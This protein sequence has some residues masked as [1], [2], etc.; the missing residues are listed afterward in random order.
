MTSHSDT[1][2]RVGCK[3]WRQERL[4]ALCAQ[5]KLDE[6]ASGLPSR[7]AAKRMADRLGIAPTALSNMLHGAKNIGDEAAR[8]IEARLGLAPGALDAP[9]HC[10]AC[11][12][13]EELAAMA[14][15]LRALRLARSGAQ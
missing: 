2:A 12:S 1:L 7:G 14:E 6:E 9:L 11:E 5:A 13:A 4:A 10:L 3:A 15:A 8:A